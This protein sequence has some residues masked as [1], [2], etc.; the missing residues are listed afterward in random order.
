M[1]KSFNYKDLN[2]VKHYNFGIGSISNVWKI[3]KLNK[4][5]INSTHVDHIGCYNFDSNYMNIQVHLGILFWI[6]NL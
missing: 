2:L 5:F 1:K 3:Q 4:K 6:S